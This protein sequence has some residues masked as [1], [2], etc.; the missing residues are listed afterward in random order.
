MH[1]PVSY[2]FE[3][4]EQN[5]LLQEPSIERIRL[6]HLN[7]KIR[8]IRASV[9]T[10]VLEFKE[11]YDRELNESARAKITQKMN[12]GSSKIIFDN[13]IKSL[14]FGYILLFF[15]ANEFS[16]VQNINGVNIRKAAR[17][18]SNF[19]RHRCRIFRPRVTP[20]C[21]EYIIRTVPPLELI[22]FRHILRSYRE[23]RK[24]IR[25]LW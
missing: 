8:S 9:V 18:K 20:K 24:I 19:A 17:I 13:C 12:C 25:V 23:S 10:L 3:M 7:F 4:I 5:P 15:F 6:C 1:Q 22:P 11:K 16:K 14:Y 2:I 21:D